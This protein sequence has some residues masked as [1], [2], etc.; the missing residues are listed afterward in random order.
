VIEKRAM[1]EGIDMHSNLELSLPIY[2][3]INKIFTTNY[4][5]T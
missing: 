5:G 2:K 1:G 4:D 3:N